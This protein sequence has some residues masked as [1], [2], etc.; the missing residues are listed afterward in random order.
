MF[1]IP[2]SLFTHEDPLNVHKSLGFACLAHFIV[3]LFLFSIGC[4]Y[5]PRDPLLFGS[6]SPETP[7]LITLHAA[8][9]L[10]SLVFRLPARRIKEG[11][12]IWPEFRLHSIVFALRAL[13]SM[14]LVWFDEAYPSPTGPRYWVN[15]CIVFATMSAADLSTNLLPDISRSH[16][17]RDL[18]ASPAAKTAF[19]YMQFVGT[20]GTLLGL[21]S[22][23]GQFIVVSI[24]QVFAFTLTLRRKNLISHSAALVFYSLHLAIGFTVANFEVFIYMGLAGIALAPTLAIIAMMLRIHVGLSKYIV[25]AAMAAVVTWA[26]YTTPIVAP[27][28]RILWWPDWGWTAGLA[29]CTSFAILLESK[30]WGRTGTSLS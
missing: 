20:V 7:V 29:L 2:G 5:A 16:T 23:T 12:R 11:T 8:L 17:I 3:R 14:L 15:I 9:S 18:D 10:S 30:K 4:W 21:R 19:S 28:Q 6:A 27:H 13:L 24:I 1:G 25:W 22:Y 26:R